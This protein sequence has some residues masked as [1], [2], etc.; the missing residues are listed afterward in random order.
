MTNARN[1]DIAYDPAA[2]LP[3][4]TAEE[5]AQKLLSDDINDYDRKIIA[6]TVNEMVAT[7]KMME[8]L[9]HRHKITIFGSARTPE[10]HPDYILCRD[11]A[12]QMANLG[13]MTITGA[14][15][16]IMAAGHEGAGSENSIGVGIELPFETGLNPHTAASKHVLTFKYFFNRK[17]AF[18]REA[19]AVILFPGGFGTM[20]EAFEA[21]TLLH[22][23]RSMPVPVVLMDH[24]GSTYWDDWLKLVK[25]GLLKHQMISPEDL[26]VFRRFHNVAD[27][28]DYIHNFYRRYH[29]LRYW[30]DNGVDKVII[31]LQTPV[32]EELI[33]DLKVK[34]KDFLGDFGIETHQEA[35]PIEKDEQDIKHLPRLVLAANKKR[36][37][38]LCRF[39]RSINRD[40]TTSSTR[41]RAPEEEGNTAH[42]TPR[43]SRLKQLFTRNN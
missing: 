4:I 15:P 21:L 5:A 40:I 3:K 41:R 25:D 2:P 18:I 26:E 20:D 8:P 6:H 14:G 17:L 23:G 28:A 39:V 37:V 35:L 12:K 11:F 13:Y 42:K 33:E 34:Y 22:T 27:A 9:R 16:G 43:P 29:S 19:D 30:K 32:P 24:E 10:D 1:K 31:R 38:D 7:A 36:P